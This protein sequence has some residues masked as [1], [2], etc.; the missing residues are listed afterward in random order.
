[1]KFD[2]I[3][4]IKSRDMAIL[5]ILKNAAEPVKRYKP[6]PYHHLFMWRLTKDE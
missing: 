1:M 4:F 2:Q 3:Q 6:K 5:E